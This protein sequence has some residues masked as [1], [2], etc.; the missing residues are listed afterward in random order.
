M[1]RLVALDLDDTLLTTDKRISEGNFKALQACLDQGIHVVTASGRF[2]ESQLFFIKQI[3][4]NLEKNYHVGDGGGTIFNEEHILEIIGSFSQKGYQ[5]LLQ[6]VRESGIPCFVTNG[7]NVY[8][9]I[10]EQPL[11]DVYG[12]IQ[13]ARRPYIFKIEDLSVVEEALKFVFAYQNDEELQKIKTFGIEGSSTFHAG[14]NLMEITMKNLN[15]FAA[16]ER[17]SKLYG[18]NTN[19]M[20]CIGDSE[21]DIPMLKNAGLGM[22]VSNAMECVKNSADIVGEKTNDEDGV[23]WLLERYVL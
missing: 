17:I 14:R 13:N 11:C 21:N 18:V 16:L 3:G 15:K 5:A 12:R 10:D 19:E 7:C 6:Q 2:N 9:D 20:V 8:Y 1:Y 23:A 4:L 22:A